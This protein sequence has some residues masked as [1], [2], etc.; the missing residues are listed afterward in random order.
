MSYSTARA[1]AIPAPPPPGPRGPGL[2]LALGWLLAEPWLFPRWRERYG[3]VFMLH[4]TGFAPPLVVVADPALAKQVFAG[5]PA[6]LR[7]GDAN[8]GPLKELV[9][10]QSLLL[11]D[12]PRHPQRRKLNVPPSS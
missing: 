3:D 1:N 11:L 7:A 5:D 6:K 9:G 10:S 2:A 12:A 8:G 4:A